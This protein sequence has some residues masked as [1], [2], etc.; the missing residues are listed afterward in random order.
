MKTKREL[1][2]CAALVVHFIRGFAREHVGL[3]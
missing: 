2:H 1:V 3:G